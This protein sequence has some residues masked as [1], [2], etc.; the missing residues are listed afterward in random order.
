[1]AMPI[2]AP[3]LM[4]GHSMHAAAAMPVARDS[5]NAALAQPRPDP[6][7][8]TTPRPMAHA[9]SL[10]IGLPNPTGAAL[11]GDAGMAVAD[12]TPA[13]RAR[14]PTVTPHSLAWLVPPDLTVL[15]VSRT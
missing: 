10:C 1:M 3:S 4:A 13:M 2:G 15:G 12:Y 5:T 7:G 6:G 9:D 11:T 8:P 14:Q